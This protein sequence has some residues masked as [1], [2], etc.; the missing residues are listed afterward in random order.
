MKTLKTLALLLLGAILVGC[1]EEGGGQNSDNSGLILRADKY[2]IY[3]NGTDVATFR[4]TYNGIEVTEGYTIYDN[5]DEPLNGKTFSSTIPGVYKFWAEYGDVQ[6]KSDATITVVTTPPAAPAVPTDNNPTKLDFNR[7]VLLVQFTG[8]GCPNCPRMINALDDIKKDDVLKNKVAIASA[9][10]G[11]YANGDPAEM[12]TELNLDDAY[13]IMYNP[14]VIADFKR[15]NV[16][17]ATASKAFVAKMINDRLTEVETRGSVAV[18]SEYHAEKNYIVLNTLVKAKTSAE[19]RIGAML[20]EDNIEAVQSNNNITPNEGVNF[21]NHENCIRKVKSQN[22][23]NMD[24]FTGF[25]LGTIEAGKTKSYEFA[26]PVSKS[27]KA[28]NLHLLVFVSTKEKSGK[29]YVNNV[30][31]APINGSVDFEYAE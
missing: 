28:E 5:N 3:D 16:E 30:T 25:D 23:N 14:D 15:N 19:F 1:N 4:L 29:W 31:A 21:N 11:S 12:T 17:A 9:H 27:W 10:I 6:T 22:P 7:R 20:L 26:F 18:N 2:E 13:A 24:D 8:I